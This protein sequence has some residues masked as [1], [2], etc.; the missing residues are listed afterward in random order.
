MPINKISKHT[1]NVL[2]PEERH[3]FYETYYSQGVKVRFDK[4]KIVNLLRQLGFYR[5]DIPNSRQSEMV[6]IVDNKIRI[7][8]LTEIRDAFEDYLQTL[9]TIERTFYTNSKRDGEDEPA[10][11]IFRITPEFLIGKMYD[12]LQTLFSS[13]LMER[14]RPLNHTINIQEDTYNQK[15]IFFNN[16]ALKISKDGIQQI[17]YTKLNNYIWENSIINKD[18]V[19][20]NTIG[21]FEKFISDICKYDPTI[22]DKQA[23]YEGQQRKQSL[24]SILGY[25]MHNNYETNRKAILFTDIN[26]DGAQEANGRTGKGIL[27]KA[28]AQMLN[29]ERGDCRYL[30][31]PG[32]GFEFKDTRYAAGDLTTQLIHIEDIEKRFDFSEMFNDVTDG[33]VFR[34]LHQNPTIHDS[35]IMISVNHT[36]NLFNSESKRGRVVIFE[37]DNY[38]KSDYTPEMKYGKRFFE[39]K[40]TATDWGQFYSFMV[41]CVLVYMQNGLIEPSMINYENRLIEEQLPEDFVYFFEN[42]IEGAVA[43]K[44]RTEYVK[45]SIYDRFIMKYPQYAK[46]QQSGFSKWCIQ[47]LQLKHIRSAQL[48]KKIGG[49]YT[50]CIV[51][52]QDAYEKVYKYIVQ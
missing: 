23:L 52:Y 21:D 19:E 44:Q 46:Y 35:K 43:H 45:R 27:G 20:D 6:R 37:L 16:T 26:E 18:Y 12:N 9:P 48:R 32:K 11:K 1:D 3:N 2:T 13:D 40:W 24:M 42:E 4:L 8:N 14:L 34:K 15:Y 28:L 41:R 50:D 5:Y 10:K 49:D 7:V 25:L 22:S 39:S 31:V 38:Y 36:I 47:Y 17:P 51:L 30:V 33:C 29:R